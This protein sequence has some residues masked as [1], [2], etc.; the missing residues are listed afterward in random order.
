MQTYQKNNKNNKISSTTEQLKRRRRKG[1]S[2]NLTTKLETLC[3]LEDLAYISFIIYLLPLC[4]LYKGV[5]RYRFEGW[6]P[7]LTSL[8]YILHNLYNLHADSF[9]GKVFWSFAGVFEYLLSYNVLSTYFQD[10]RICT[11]VG[12]MYLK[13]FWNWGIKWNGLITALLLL[14]RVVSLS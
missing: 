8:P 10:C 14:S 9:C 1:S 6:L 7:S 13:L 4:R 2:N 11:F 12:D 5:K 3:S